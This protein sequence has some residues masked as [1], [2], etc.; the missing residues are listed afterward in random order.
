MAFNTLPL[1]SQWWECRGPEVTAI[2]S[3][4]NA[5]PKDHC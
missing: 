4:K 3:R 5:N 2:I 1:S